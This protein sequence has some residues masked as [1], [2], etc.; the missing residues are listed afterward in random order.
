[1]PLHIHTQ[2]C[3]QAFLIEVSSKYVYG[4][5]Q[6]I[7]RKPKPNRKFHSFINRRPVPVHIHTHIHTLTKSDKHTRRIYKKITCVLLYEIYHNQ[8]IIESELSAATASDKAQSSTSQPGGSAKSHFSIRKHKAKSKAVTP[9]TN[10]SDAA[11]ASEPSTSQQMTASPTSNDKGMPTS[12]DQNNNTNDNQMRQLR[13]DFD[14][15]NHSGGGVNVVGGASAGDE[16]AHGNT[17]IEMKTMDSLR[18]HRRQPSIG[19]NQDELAEGGIKQQH[20]GCIQI[21][22]EHADIVEDDKRRMAHDVSSLTKKNK[23]PVLSFG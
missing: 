15:V 9:E 21:P 19:A 3:M 7:N 11:A 20:C 13:M 1:M 10:A 5:L 18:L 23:L 16:M 6:E 14:V 8:E 17:E 2:Q 22:I 12:N 4:K